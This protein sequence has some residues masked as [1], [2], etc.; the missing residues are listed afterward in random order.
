LPSCSLSL[1]RFSEGTIP[2]PLPELQWADDVGGGG[3]GFRLRRMSR[4]IKMT[5]WDSDVSDSVGCIS[6]IW[7]N[8]DYV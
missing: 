7:L 6:C 2:H 4:D 1:F 3:R 5:L 8:N